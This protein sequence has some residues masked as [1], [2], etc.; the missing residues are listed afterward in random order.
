MVCWVIAGS[1]RVS[2]GAFGSIPRYAASCWED[3]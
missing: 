1:G 2:G 3:G